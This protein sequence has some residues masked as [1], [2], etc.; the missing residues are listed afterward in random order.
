MVAR[1][2]SRNPAQHFLLDDRKGTLDV[3]KDADIVI[4]K[5]ER[6]AFDPSD[7]L[8]AVQWSSFEGREFTVRVAATWC[9]GQLVFDG[10]RIVNQKGDGRFLRP[11]QA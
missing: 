9:R 3:G 5:P 10:Q 11:R 8:S 1:Q 6:Y 4:L 2:L 7:S